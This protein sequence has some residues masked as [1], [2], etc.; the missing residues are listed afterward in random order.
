[1]AAPVLPPVTP[2]PFKILNSAVIFAGISLISVQLYNN[3]WH[4]TFNKQ[5]NFLT[6]KHL[7]LLLAVILSVRSAQ[8]QGEP[9]SKTVINTGYNLEHPFEI[10]LSAQDDSL[11]VNTRSGRIYKIHKSNGGR[12]EILNIVSSVMFTRNFDGGGNVTGIAQDGMF[13]MALHPDAFK[14]LGK[15]SLYV[16]YCYNS[17][18][19]VRRTRIAKYWYNSGTKM[20]TNGSTLIQGLPGSDDHNGGRLVIG[21]DKKLYYSCGDQGANQFGNACIEIKS[22]KD[23]SA[24]ELS[25][26][27]YTDYAGHILRMNLDGSIPSDN[28]SFA[29]VQSNVFSKGHRNPQG[30]VFEKDATG[31]TF[32]GSKLF[33]S[34]QGAVIDD[35]VNIIESGKNYG[36][37]HISGYN[38]NIFY[39]YKN[40]SLSPSA[41]GATN[42]TNYANE[43][44]T[45]TNMTGGSPANP[46]RTESSWTA[47]DYTSPVVSQ[48]PVTSPDCS[49][50]LARPTVAWSS[51]EYYTSTTG[52]P[53]WS[54]SLLLTTLKRSALIRYKLNVTNT[55]VVDIPA[56]AFDTIQYF[57]D[58]AALNRFRDV[59]ISPTGII[60]YL[61]TDSVGAT[62]GPSNGTASI[63]DRGKVIAYRFTGT[64]LSLPQNNPSERD[65]NDLVKVYPNPA[66][67]YIVVNTKDLIYRPYQVRLVDVNG[68]AVY[69]GQITNALEQIN[70]KN[71]PNGQYMVVITNRNNLTISTRKIIV[72]K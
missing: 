38:D 34:E 25:A 48:F 14:G 56:N 6:M 49:N 45:A 10:F 12:R 37:P 71:I 64:S 32:S 43:C 46:P 27:D 52:I 66:A 33:E 15:D 31:N 22:Q 24:A 67:D 35:E 44:G 23:I 68:K 65:V 54:N 18:G 40:W 58:D 53:G 50:W 72:N 16:A 55:G 51:I 3:L 5:S 69:Q 28:P 9:F 2:L 59:A 41:S 20:L 8:A 36:W 42:C 47:S 57:R 39:T 29:G 21:F 17:G 30:L 19:G 62:S 11:W 7:I 26:A 61:I 63:T 13:G 4:H 60:L 1:M 70:V